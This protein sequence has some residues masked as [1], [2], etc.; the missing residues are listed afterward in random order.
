MLK[1]NDK[2]HEFGKPEDLDILSNSFWADTWPRFYELF[3]LFD[4]SPTNLY[5]VSEKFS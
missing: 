4:I 5:Q 3:E 2:K 1:I